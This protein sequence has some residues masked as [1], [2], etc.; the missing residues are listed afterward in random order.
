MQL[1]PVLLEQWVELARHRARELRE[2]H[3]LG[4]KLDRPGVEPRQVEQ[5]HR[6]LLEAR[7]LLAHRL[8]ELTPGLL[9]E[10]LVLEQLHEPAQR[11]DRRAQLVRGGRD[12]LL[13]RHVDPA[14]LLLHLVEGLR[15][16]AELVLRGDGKGLHEAPAR[17]VAGGPLEA[18]HATRQP[19]RHEVSAEERDQERRAGGQEHAVAHEGH[20]LAHVVEVAR[21]E[22]HPRQLAGGGQGL[23]HHPDL[24]A[25]EGAVPAPACGAG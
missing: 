21:V 13:A 18:A 15:E 9:V 7:H 22:R 19:R 10:I 6:Q 5:V 17:H 8:Q 4:V 25:A 1:G 12:E 14:Q 3:G 23:G 2:V 20:G 24:L 11:E 16:L